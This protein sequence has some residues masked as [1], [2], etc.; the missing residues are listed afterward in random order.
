[1]NALKGRIKTLVIKAFP[2]YQKSRLRE[3]FNQLNL[4]ED[5][6]EEKELLLLRFWLN[7]DSIFFDIGANEG[8]YTYVAQLYTR[9]ENIYVF[10]PIQELSDRLKYMFGSSNHFK[11]ALSDER[12][13]HKFKIPII[14]N[15][16][17]KSRGTLNTTY[18]EKGEVDKRIIE[19]KTIPLDEF[20]IEN[21][22]GRIN[23]IKIDVEGHELEVIKGGSETLKKLRPVLQIEIEQRHHLEKIDK[24]IEYVNNLGYKC[25]YLDLQTRQ[26][27]PL[28][29]RPDQIQHESEFK[30][31]D[32]VNNFLFLPDQREWTSKLEKI[33][34]QI[35]KM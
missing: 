28:N 32:Y 33:N 35:L 23:F 1:M 2:Y 13:N 22:I 27:V 17:L 8:L 19:V 31:G 21:K 34:H 24:I 7:S 3:F 14:G 11:M 12:S 26:I 5:S 9:Q 6:S 25:H 15:H 4:N 10:E 29:I 20:C 30:K 16:E 18:K